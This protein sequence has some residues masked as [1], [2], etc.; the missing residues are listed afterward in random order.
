MSRRSPPRSL[1]EQFPERIEGR[2]M[3]PARSL[4]PAG[5][6]GALALSLLAHVAMAAVVAHQSSSSPR[7]D[8]GTE[9]ERLV[10][11]VAPELVATP[12]EEGADAPKPQVLGSQAAPDRTRRAAASPISSRAPL[13]ESVHA[14][15]PEPAFVPSATP[16]PHFVMASAP[17]SVSR[18]ETATA[19]APGPGAAP[20]PAPVSEREV[21]VPA[22]RVAGAAPAYPASAQAAGIE[23][24]VPVELVVDAGGSVRSAVALTH[25]GYGL[26]ASAIAA[27]RSWRFAPARRNGQAVAVRMHW[28]VRFELR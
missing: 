20:A 14:S 17:V 21:D 12:R 27:V 4:T 19:L 5:H 3:A 28:D 16:A 6:G 7:S 15:T 8:A 1:A 11:I 18:E 2:A 23:A 25:V 26:E 13:I 10:E 9:R 24:S 22:R